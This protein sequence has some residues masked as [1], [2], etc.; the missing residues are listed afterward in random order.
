MQLSTV[1]CLCY[2]AVVHRLI[3]QQA[4]SG[5]LKSAIKI[6][7]LSDLSPDLTHFLAK[8]KDLFCLF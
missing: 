1:S 8:V 5:G 6:L 4:W 3:P 2:S 7:E